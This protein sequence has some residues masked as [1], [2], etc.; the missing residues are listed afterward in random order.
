M[1]Y[2]RLLLAAKKHE[3]HEKTSYYPDD[4]IHGFYISL[5]S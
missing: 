3:K 1:F 5:I 4:F 2:F